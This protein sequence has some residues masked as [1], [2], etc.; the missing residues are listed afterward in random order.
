ML[1]EG[2]SCSKRFPPSAYRGDAGIQSLC[3]ELE[4]VYYN[5]L[6]IETIDPANDIIIFSLKSHIHMTQE[7]STLRVNAIYPD[8]G[9]VDKEC[10]MV[11]DLIKDGFDDILLK[12]VEEEGLFFLIET[13]KGPMYVVPTTLFMNGIAKAAN[14]GRPRKG[15]SEYRDLYLSEALFEAADS[16][17]RVKVVLLDG[18]EMTAKGLSC[19]SFQ[20]PDTPI[21]SIGDMLTRLQDEFGQVTIHSY[22]ISHDMTSVDMAFGRVTY[23]DGKGYQRGCRFVT[24]DTGFCAS[25]L[26]ALIMVD[27]EPVLIPAMTTKKKYREF[28][29]CTLANAFIKENGDILKAAISEILPICKQS[30]NKARA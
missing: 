29:Y 25:S 21:Q 30:Q 3:K 5:R 23:K 10:F 11:D 9:D 24:S 4:S 17:V 19:A 12:E 22:S 6:H 20:Y 7:T 15:L 2:Y 28:T 1:H 8:S 14:I 26:Q 27:D 13:S 18:E 16:G